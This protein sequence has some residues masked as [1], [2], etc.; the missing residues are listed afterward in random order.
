MNPPNESHL[1]T[2]WNLSVGLQAWD[3]CLELDI[4]RD[5]SGPTGGIDILVVITTN[6]CFFGSFDSRL[7][8]AY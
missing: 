7:G 3:S 6:G 1:L 2:M 8:F 5:V 4:S